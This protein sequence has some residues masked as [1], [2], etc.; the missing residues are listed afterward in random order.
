[1]AKDDA[2]VEICFET[3]S[4]PITYF[5]P[6]CGA[7]LEIDYEYRVM[8]ESESFRPCPS[9]DLEVTYDSK[10]EYVCAQC[11]EYVGSEPSL[12]AIVFWTI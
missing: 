8:Q 1:M 10:G 2:Q 6:N 4:L 11:G 5:C 9:G 3:A 7:S 12:P